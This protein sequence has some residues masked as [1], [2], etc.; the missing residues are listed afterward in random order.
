MNRSSRRGW[1]IAIAQAEVLL[2]FG[3]TNSFGTPTE[4]KK[5]QRDNQWIGTWDS[6]PN[7]A[8]SREE[9]G[10]RSLREGES[11]DIV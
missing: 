8:E 2:A 1:K 4:H 5:R 7:V 3:A 11:R 10:D 6:S 9:F